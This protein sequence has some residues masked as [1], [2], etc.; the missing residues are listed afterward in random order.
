MTFRSLF[1]HRY[2][3]LIRNDIEQRLMIIRQQDV[4]LYLN[5]NKVVVHLNEPIDKWI[6]WNKAIECAATSPDYTVPN[7][8]L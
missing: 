1:T 4:V 6:R 7:T 2:L 3:N 8:F 5:V